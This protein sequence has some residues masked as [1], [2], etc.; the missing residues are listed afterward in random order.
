MWLWKFR[1]KNEQRAEG[2]IKFTFDVN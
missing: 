1:V 2:I